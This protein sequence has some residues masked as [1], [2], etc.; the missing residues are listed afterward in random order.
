MKKE[1]WYE[2][3]PI[4]KADLDREQ[5]SKEEA[6]SERLLDGVNSGVLLES[7]LL[8]EASAL[9]IQQGPNAGLFATVNTGVA[10]S[11]TGERIAVSAVSA[12]NAAA[13]TTTTDNGIGSTALTPQSTGTQNIPLTNNATNSIWIGYLETTDPTVFTLQDGTNERLFVSRDDGFEIQVTTNSTNPD[14]SRYVLLG[15]VVTAAGAVTS[16]NTSN[17]N[18]ALSVGPT[19]I[20]GAPYQIALSLF[21]NLPAEADRP[22]SV[23][24][25]AGFTYTT[26]TPAAG[27]FTVNFKTG[28]LTFNAADTG[29]NV[30]IDYLAQHTRRSLCVSRSGRPGAYI[31]VNT[32]P[33]SYEVG[34][35]T[36]LTDH[37]NA[38]GTGPVTISN[39]H[40]LAASDIGLAGV[41]DLGGT[42][43][44]SGIVISSGD[45]GSISS[46]LSPAAV[47]AF[48]IPANLVTIAPLVAGETLNINGT[49][50]TSTD[51]PSLVTF[52]FI[53][54]L[55]LL[56]LPAGIYVFYVDL[57]TKTLMRALGA[58]PSNSFAVASIQWDGSKLLLPITDLR[59]FGTTGKQN[60]RLETILAL[61]TGAATDN[62]MTTIYSAKLTG[63]VVVTPPTYAYTALGGTT[64]NVT[65][66]GT[67]ASAVFPALPANTTIDAA[68]AAI[69]SQMPSITAIKTATNQIKL[70]APVSLLITAGTAASILGFP[71]TP[72]SGSSD[73]GNIKEI[74][75]SGS[76]SSTGVGGEVIDAEIILT[77]DLTPEQKLTSVVA[78]M[79]N[80]V[81][82]TLLTYNADDTLKTVQETTT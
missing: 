80:K 64:L 34:A 17:N 60:L 71:V 11:A 77:Y 50:V 5:A 25:I 67:P 36:T 41:L 76:T 56:P 52:N 62:R 32:K 79:G 2:D 31:T 35:G 81:L 1:R 73:S 37:V 13:P 43:A 54:S 57:A 42:L 61:A 33:S 40:G 18:E 53:D 70:L 66:D 63:S 6:I 55:T 7:Q 74:R 45:A 20:P 44:T 28:V 30:T 72:A 10:Y 46:S 47:S 3:Q 14:A 21:P 16:I 24:T 51:I 15:E 59:T 19:P 75:V 26:G 9:L 68:V 8:G 48:S 27:Q 65:V 78:T 82:T 49:L 22:S 29:T 4:L 39:P 23:P 12:F 38:R 58:A 69:N